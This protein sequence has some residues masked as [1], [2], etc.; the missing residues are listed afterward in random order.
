MIRTSTGFA[1]HD[2]GTAPD[3]AGET[4]AK[5]KSDLGL[6]PN[7]YGVLAESP[8]ALE[9]YLTLQTLSMASSLSAVER[10]VVWLE[11]NYV[12]RCNYCM[13]GHSAMAGSQGTPQDVI[14]DLREGRPLAD[15]KLQALRCFT[16]RVVE[17]RGVLEPGEVEAVMAAGFDRC[18]VLDLILAVTQKTLSNYVNH[19]ADTPAD[20]PFGKFAWTHPDDRE[21]AA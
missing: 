5:V 2:E 20:G 4:L 7:L 11:V 21:G 3:G 13:A 14:D 10:N 8:Q 15:P 12:N 1:V 6:I 17:T 18:A 9:G 16:T 19:L